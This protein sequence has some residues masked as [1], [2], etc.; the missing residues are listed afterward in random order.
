MKF[1][2]VGPYTFENLIKGGFVYVDKTEDIYDLI[3]P[4]IGIYFLSRPRRFGKSLLVSTLRAIFEGKRELFEDLW[5]GQHTDYAF[6][7]YHIIALDMSRM[8]METPALFKESVRTEVEQ[9]A[10]SFGVGLEQ[11]GHGS[12]FGELIRKLGQD[13]PVVVLIDEYDKPLLNHLTTPMR[14]EMKAALKAFYIAIKA[15]D[16]YLR[17]VLLTGVTKFSKVSVFSDLNNLEDIS[18]QSIYATLLGFT[19]TELETYFVEHQRALADEQSM[20][21]D[22]LLERVRVWYNGYRFTEKD[23]QVYN[24]FSTLMLLEQRRFAHHWFETGTPTFLLELIKHTPQSWRQIPQEK[25]AAAEDFS[26]YEVER[27]YPLPLLFQ[28]GYLTI[29]DVRDDYMQRMYLLDYPNF[30]VE[31]AFLGEILQHFSDVYSQSSYLYRLIEFFEAGDID[32]VLEELKVFF[33]SVPYDLHM[34]YERYYQTIF[35]AIFKLLGFNIDT[36][37]KT[38]RGRV[39]AVVDMADVTYLFEFKLF[40]TKE[41]ALEQIKTQAYFQPF[42]RKGKAVVMVGVEFD[43][44]ERNIGAWVTEMMQDPNHPTNL[45]KLGH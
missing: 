15:S 1:L 21:L 9:L 25:W 12:A 7:A 20:P 38:N 33:A 19:Q 17:F 11:K 24:P 42:L 40:D 22:A 5:I 44:E 35:F 6:D 27:L 43:K 36:E 8:N 26:I 37:V 18:M 34:K 31:T 29:R 32:E 14:D 10:Q 16:R 41:S 3:R 28:A 2:P 45:E 4:P 13:K 39:D 23:I 30:E